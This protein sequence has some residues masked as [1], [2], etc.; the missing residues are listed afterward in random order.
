M[1]IPT[2]HAQ[3]GGQT[4]VCKV[5][6]VSTLRPFKPVGPAQ[7]QERIHVHKRSPRLHQTCAVRGVHGGGPQQLERGRQRATRVV[8][9]DAVDS[10]GRQE[11]FVGEALKPDLH[12]GD[13]VVR[14]AV[15]FACDGGLDVS[16]G[17]IGEF[18]GAKADDPSACDDVAFGV[19]LQSA[20][21]SAGKARGGVADVLDNF[22]IAADK[23]IAID[24]YFG[25]QAAV[26]RNLR[27][28]AI[29]EGQR[30]RREL[31]IG[32]IQMGRYFVG[33]FLFSRQGVHKSL[34]PKIECRRSP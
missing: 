6:S 1:P 22:Q 15:F 23:R 26:F 4:S 2:P 18:D 10:I 34:H 25:I 33:H 13:L 5:S 12:V 7:W 3:A 30:L 31:R 11:A 14:P 19:V 8:S 9:G 32:V 24:R 28:T 29:F 16:C 27:A 21:Q 17:V 20:K